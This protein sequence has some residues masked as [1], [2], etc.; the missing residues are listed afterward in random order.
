VYAHPDVFGAHHSRRTGVDR[1]I[2]IPPASVQVLERLKL[3]T[4]IAP[5]EVCPGVWTTGE[6][7]R[8]TQN[9]YSEALY[10]DADGKKPDPLRDDMALVLRHRSGLILLLGCA[11]AGVIDTI[12]HVEELFPNEPFLGILGGMHLNGA[13]PDTLQAVAA[14]LNA[15]NVRFVAPGHCTGD[16]TIQFLKTSMGQRVYPLHV[17]QRLEINGTDKQF[18]ATDAPVL[19]ESHP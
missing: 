4:S 2:G 17:A 15:K 19:R 11:H 10:A 6:I 5:I 9:T 13:G 3:S 18:K 1:N 8:V 12:R 7:R 16:T 14:V